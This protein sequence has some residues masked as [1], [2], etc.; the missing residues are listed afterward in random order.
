LWRWRRGRRV[1][2]VSRVATKI[3]LISAW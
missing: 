1:W 3:I 2:A